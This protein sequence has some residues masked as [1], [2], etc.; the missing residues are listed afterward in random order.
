MKQ[1]IKRAMIALFPELGA[2]LHLDRSMELHRA[3][4]F[5]R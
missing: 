2:G 1:A 3:A 5:K 4:S